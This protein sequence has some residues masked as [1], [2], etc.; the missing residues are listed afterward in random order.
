[1]AATAGIQHR[2]LIVLPPRHAAME[3]AE[4]APTQA[5]EAEVDPI[6]AVEVARIRVAEGAALT[7]IA[8]SIFDNDS[9]E[10]RFREVGTGLTHLLASPCLIRV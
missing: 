8:K 7:R 2:T 10:A 6:P 9:V 3:V 4:A 5:V 1:M